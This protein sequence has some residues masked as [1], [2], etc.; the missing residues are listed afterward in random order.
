MEPLVTSPYFELRLYRMLPTRMPD[1]HDLLGVQVPP[2]Y[3]KNGIPKP[4]GFWE[5][6][7]G[8]LS[9]LFAY[10]IP[11]DGIDQ[12]LEAWARFYADPAWLEKL[13]ANYAGEQRVGRADVHILRPSDQWERFRKTGAAVEVDGLHEMRI[14]ARSDGTPAGSL[15]RL[16]ELGAEVLGVFEGWIGMPRDRL[17]SFLAWPDEK[18][19]RRAHRD[20]G[21][22]GEGSIDSHILLPIPYGIPRSNLS[23]SPSA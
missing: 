11:W 3:E 5:G 13:A 22:G 8:Q 16:A 7:S 14:E 1:F 9:P 15:E 19:M 20:G 6:Y 23:P 18:T 17:V 12:R 21:S 2:L 10:L 4:L